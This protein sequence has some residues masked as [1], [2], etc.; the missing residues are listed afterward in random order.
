MENHKNCCNNENLI[1]D[2]LNKSKYKNIEKKNSIVST[3]P[4]VV[5][6]WHPTLNGNLLPSQVTKGSEIKAWFQCP[7]FQ[8]HQWQEE[9]W[10]ATKRNGKCP[11]CNKGR[12]KIFISNSLGSI[13][14][15]FLEYWDYELN[16]ISPYEISPKSNK[17][18]HWICKIN[19]KHKFKTSPNQFSRNYFANNKKSCCSICSNQKIE[20]C[21]C[22]ATLC[23]EALVQWDSEKNKKDGISPYEISM[24]S[25]V[26][27][28]WKCPINP[29]HSWR[30]APVNRISKEGK[31]VG[32]CIFCINQAVC[33][34][35]CLA[36]K[37]P[38]IAKQWHPTK[39]GD[40][41]PY[42][43]VP[44]CYTKKIW[45]ICLI[46][47][48]E[49]EVKP[50]KRT[51][52]K[53]PTGCPRCSKSFGEQAIEKYLIE[54]DIIFTDQQHFQTC[55]NITYLRFD[56]AIELNDR[57][58]CIEYQGEQH[59]VSVNFGSKTEDQTKKKFAQLQKRDQIKRDWCKE[60]N[61]PLLE[62]PFWEF[63]NINS[64]LEK[65]IR[66]NST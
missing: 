52:S 57:N 15:E 64:I 50:Q 9:I 24:R 62:I 16:K 63:E 39:N 19:P 59:F 53:K 56:F 25:Y 23:P 7:N 54:N 1:L 51:R 5:K 11:G 47:N 27:V 45:W 10:I 22:L 42:D 17:K 48:K 12:K 33:I 36:T 26:K 8:D 34:D 13:Y 35:N 46:C 58:C 61:V 29:N 41:T 44:G 55:K 49:W 21:N 37:F 18:I 28:W 2:V 38:E 20:N 31:L 66:E 4:D 32:N 65:F 60:N 6:I 30:S 40:L 43:V 14:P 3:H